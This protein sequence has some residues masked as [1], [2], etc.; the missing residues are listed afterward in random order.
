MN[1][2]GKCE[3]VAQQQTHVNGN[4]H[5]SVNSEGKEQ[6]DCTGKCACLNVLHMNWRLNEQDK[7]VLVLEAAVGYLFAN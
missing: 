5:Y 6:I 2:E 1:K 3:L 4:T 7:E